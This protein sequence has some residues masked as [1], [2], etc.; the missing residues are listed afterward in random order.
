MSDDNFD[1]LKKLINDISDEIDSGNQNELDD[2]I[3]TILNQTMNDASGALSKKER[4]EKII[5]ILS[6]RDF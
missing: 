4:I 5:S 2:V 1:D 3:L 6:A